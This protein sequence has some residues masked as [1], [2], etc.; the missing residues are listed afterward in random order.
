MTVPGHQGREGRA[1]L[2]FFCPSK[3]LARTVIQRRQAK[4]NAKDNVKWLQ[5]NVLLT[6]LGPKKVTEELCSTTSE[7]HKSGAISLWNKSMDLMIVSHR[8]NVLK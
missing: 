8:N 3:V 4:D 6:C 7:E 2:F 1:H 5:G